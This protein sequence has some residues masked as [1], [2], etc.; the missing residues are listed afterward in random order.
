[1]GGFAQWTIN[2][3]SIKSKLGNFGDNDKKICG[4][5]FNGN[6]ALTGTV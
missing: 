4:L 2:A 5:A 6:I 1:M 3:K